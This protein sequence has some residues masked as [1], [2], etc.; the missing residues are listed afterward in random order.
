MDWLLAPQYWLARVAFQRLLGLV[1]LIAFISA[2]NQFTALVGE[3]GLMPH[4]RTR[5]PTIFTLHYT[6]RF[7]RSVAAIGAGLSAVVMLGGVDHTPLV[8]TMLAWAALWALY[9]SFVHAGQMFFGFVWET[10]LLEAGF[11]A[12][13][14]GNSRVAP[15]LPAVLLLRWLLF[16]LEVGAGLIKLRSDR[17]WRDLTALY[18]HHETQPI[19]NRFSAWFHQLPKPVHK[20]E[21][22]G[23]HVAQLVVPIALFLPQPIA[24]VAGLVVIVTQ[25]WLMLSGNF[26]WL[27]L[28]TIA[29]AVSALDNGVLAHLLP[30]DRPATLADP[31]GWFVATVL[32]VTAVVVVLSRRPVRNMASRRQMM[33]VSYNRL[34]V[35]SS[36]GLFGRITRERL[37]IA[38]EGTADS[39]SG[40]DTAWRAY[41][42]KAKPVDP[43]HRPRQ[44]A[45]YHLRLDWLMWF[46]AISPAYAEPWFVTFLAKLLENDPATLRL[47]GTN[48]FPEGPP[49]FVRAQLYRYRFASRAERAR[50]GV[51]WRRDFLG[52]FVPPIALRRAKHADM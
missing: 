51:W 13:W 37:E 32:T 16:R 18:Y 46:A 11:L 49:T 38:I 36:Y 7:A 14:L 50:T 35:A 31:P 33:N 28:L 40:E 25:L 44:V 3:R 47:L 17:A 48:P 43:R 1:Y 8:V 10:L 20:L 19:P 15:L 12:I 45:P 4:V 27:N 26:A 21:V 41:A 30:L 52:D 29:L 22:A 2:F 23:N 5:S 39:H 6:D 24:S 9:M 34:H 42:F